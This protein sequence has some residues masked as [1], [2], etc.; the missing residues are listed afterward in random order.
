MML[1]HTNEAR[2]N[3]HFRWRGLERFE[4]A[5]A[6]RELVRVRAARWRPGLDLVRDRATAPIRKSGRK[7]LIKIESTH[8]RHAAIDPGGLSDPVF[9]LERM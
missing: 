1:I 7:A 3:I 9:N 6:G 2:R 8:V 4:H 5:H